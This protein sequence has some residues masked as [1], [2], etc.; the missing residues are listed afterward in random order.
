MSDVFF[1]LSFLVAIPPSISAYLCSM[2]TDTLDT[3][4]AAA[5][6]Y[7]MQEYPEGSWIACEK[8]QYDF[9]KTTYS[10][11]TQV[12]PKTAPTAQKIAATPTYTPKVES[13]KKEAPSRQLPPQTSSVHTP[14]KAEEQ[15]TVLEPIQQA[16]HPKSY[17]LNALPKPGAKIEPPHLA[18][19]RAK[20]EKAKD[21]PTAPER[22][23][24][25]P[26]SLIISLLPAGSEA[27]GF[28]EKMNSAI[29]ER[30][31]KNSLCLDATFEAL[32]MLMTYAASGNLKAV[33]IAG[34]I[35]RALDWLMPLSELETS[36]EQIGPLQL[37]TKLYGVPIY[38]LALSE[39]PNQQDKA[40][41]WKALQQIL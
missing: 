29:Q 17:I 39:V 19:V 14:E 15:S 5:K 21:V 20:L 41:L 2:T 18:D 34:D 6:L 12:T 38:F 9:F 26:D 35:H 31:N 28:I 37:R 22:K 16:V 40:A 10:A 13:A 24:V 4:I 25:T 3:L 27:F 30:L 36:S 1:S 23:I 7:I 11:P 8:A 32:A 33:I